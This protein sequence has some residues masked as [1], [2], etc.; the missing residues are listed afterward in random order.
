[1]A[2]ILALGA[3]GYLFYKNNVVDVRGNSSD[4]VVMGTEDNAPPNSFYVNPQNT[5]NF[6]YATSTKGEE[7]VN[8]KF[9]FI[10]SNS[11]RSRYQQQV[12]DV[13]LYDEHP[14]IDRRNYNSDFNA[15]DR[16]AETERVFCNPNPN[17]LPI[18][19]AH[20]H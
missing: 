20:E 3:L 5:T 10:L 12:N 14:M 7:R 15:Q 17:Q 8:D 6:H 16:I 11:Y 13:L 18:N 19:I 2:Y 4:R 1:M 9:D